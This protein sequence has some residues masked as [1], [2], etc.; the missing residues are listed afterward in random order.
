MQRIQIDMR[1]L[2]EAQKQALAKQMVKVALSKMNPE[3]K[4]IFILHLQRMAYKVAIKQ[5]LMKHKKIMSILSLPLM[6][7]TYLSTILKVML[8][9]R[10]YLRQATILMQNLKHMKELVNS[11]SRNLISPERKKEKKVQEDYVS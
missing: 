5:K 6:P 9:R 7:I 1:N 11:E 4:K 8:L 2:S 10:M 3:Q